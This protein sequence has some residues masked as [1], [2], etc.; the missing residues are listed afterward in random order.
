MGMLHA[1]QQLKA[2]ETGAIVQWIINWYP[3][4]KYQYH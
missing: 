2:G 1:R 4:T 3:N